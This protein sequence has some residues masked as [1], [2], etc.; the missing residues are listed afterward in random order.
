LA[1]PGFARNRAGS[2]CSSLSRPVLREP[3]GCRGVRNASI[4]NETPCPPCGGR[5]LG[6]ARRQRRG[7]DRAAAAVAVRLPAHQGLSSIDHGSAGLYSART[8]TPRSALI[9]VRRRAISD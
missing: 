4:Q 3:A 6:S 7:D 8:G 1:A 5:A 9:L 2:D